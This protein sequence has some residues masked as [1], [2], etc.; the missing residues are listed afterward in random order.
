MLSAIGARAD[1][2]A[3]DDAQLQNEAKEMAGLLG[4]SVQLSIDLGKMTGIEKAPEDEADRLR[5]ALAALSAPLIA[6]QY[7]QTGRAPAENDLKRLS[8]ALEAVLTFS[9]NFTPDDAH[10]KALQEIEADGSA[11]SAHQINVQYL[12]LFTPVIDAVSRF[13]FGQQ[14]KSLMRDIAGRLTNEAT[15]L[16]KEIFGDSL[17]D[18]AEKLAELALLRTLAAIY[19]LS[20]NQEVEKLS[21][22]SD[23]NEGDIKTVWKAFETRLSM[24][25]VLG[26]NLV[27]GS[28]KAQGGGDKAPP[29]PPKETPT[30]APPQAPDETQTASPEQPAA[31]QAPAET[32]PAT[33][34]PAPPSS[35]PATTPPAGDAAAATGGPMSFFGAKKEDDTP[36]TTPPAPEAPSAEPAAEPPQAPQEP[37]KPEESAETP[38]PPPAELPKES[39]PAEAPAEDKK[40][41]DNQGGGPM[42]FFKKG[43]DE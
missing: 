2:T 3:P 6:A 15:L 38:P 40:K 23:G 18:G 22:G 9:E 37:P 33:T 26:E 20:H 28:A 12:H 19:A 17:K 39:P 34:P 16:R 1:K 36:A 31:P 30:E 14:E 42:S 27:P 8:G 32:P 43:D 7:K 29:P 21:A 41:D 5:V 35:A 11:T 25:Q 10:I 24:L 4:K 13:S